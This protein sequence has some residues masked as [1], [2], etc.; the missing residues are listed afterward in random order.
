MKLRKI[1]SFLTIVFILFLTAS[2][3]MGGNQV[4]ITSVSADP[5][6]FASEVILNNYDLRDWNII[7]TYSD[8]EQRVVQVGYNMLSIND[9]AKLSQVGEHDIVFT[10]E[11]VSFTHHLKITYPTH[12]ELEAL[13]NDVIAQELVP[14][15][16]KENFVLPST[17]EN[18]NIT[19]SFESSYLTRQGT[20][21]VVTRPS[22]S[23]GDEVVTLHAE[24]SIYDYVATHDY[25]VTILAYGQ[26]EVDDY[27]REVESYFNVP[28]SVTD[29]LELLFMYEEATIKWTSSNTSVI[30]I[31]NARQSVT[32]NPVVSETSVSLSFE[33]TY[34]G[35]T[36]SDFQAINIRVI[37]KINVTKAPSV[38]GLKVENKVAS[39]NKASGVTS[40]AVYVGSR[41]A[42]TTAEN[43]LDLSSLLVSNGTYRVSV[44]SLSGGAYNTD[45]D[46]VTVTTA[47]TDGLSY[48]GTYYNSV[49]LNVAG[50]QLKSTLRTLIT[51][52]HTSIRTYENLKTD[53]ARADALL[54]NPNKV[55]LI[56]SRYAVQAKWSS[57]GT[58]WNREHVWAQS[59]GWFSTSDAGA[60]AHHLRP[61][62]PTVNSTRGNLPFGKVTGGKQA[63]LSSA[64]GGGGSNCYYGGGYFEPQDAAKGDVARILFYLF[65]RYS[66]ADRY[67]V[68]VIAQSWTLLLQW[69]ELDPVDEW[70]MNRN[71]VVE[72]IQGN[73]NPFIDYPSLAS[74]IW[75]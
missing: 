20:K 63:M 53:L 71:D 57:G 27:L 70:E 4:K 5:D 30:V 15:V 38:S 3:E 18:V 61:E 37:P 45:S 72:S 65:V 31:D 12:E 43:S 13:V 75:G 69:N 2:C 73:R 41:L 36:Y 49:N 66:E 16:T 60:D 17:R 29:A 68:T 26:E 10:Y 42:G 33:I 40:Y 52:T 67:N 39:W 32:V 59:I 9:T 34:M 6:A 21:A 50:A 7:V 51:R 74:D 35:D 14:S 23:S 58:Y 55:L 44:V 62:D 56:Y 64:N 19:W 8:G 11:G 48:N 28:S 22:M 25:E 54:D 47:V 1:I 46:P 24:F